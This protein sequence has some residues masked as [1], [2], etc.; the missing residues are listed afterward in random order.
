MGLPRPPTADDDFDGG[1]APFDG[2]HEPFH[3][4]LRLFL[5]Q[6]SWG[7]V[8][9]SRGA[10]TKKEFDGIVD[11]YVTCGYEILDRSG[12][13]TLLR[14]RTWGSP[15]VH[16][17]LAFATFWTLGIGNL[18][19]AL[20]SHINAE[21]VVV[22][23]VPE[24]GG[25]QET[26]DPAPPP[27]TP[28]DGGIVDAAKGMVLMAKQYQPAGASI[29]DNVIVIAL[30]MMCC[31][32]VGL[33]LVWTNPRWT[34]RQ[35]GAWTL[36][37]VPLFMIG[38]CVQDQKAKEAAALL[39]EGDRLWD[40]GKR[41]EAVAK[42]EKAWSEHKETLTSSRQST[43]GVI[44]PHLPNF[45]ARLMQYELSKGDR[46][47]AERLSRQAAREGI[48]LPLDTE[49][50]HKI[51]PSVVIGDA[52]E[53][54]RGGGQV[55]R[56]EPGPQVPTGSTY[57][58]FDAGEKERGGGQ[59]GR[60]E[61]GPQVPTGSTYPKFDAGEKERGGGQVGRHEPGPQ[62]P[63]GS[64][65]PKFNDGFFTDSWDYK[66]GCQVIFDSTVP[67]T[68]AKKLGDYLER[69]GGFDNDPVTFQ[70]RKPGKTYELSLVIKKGLEQDPETIDSMEQLG[71]EL[72]RDVF[73]DGPV[74]VHLCDDRMRTLRVVVP[75]GEPE[76]P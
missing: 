26:I 13:T 38:S 18:A 28:A 12:S 22:N 67:S 53:K 32:P 25:T 4:Q 35:K 7:G 21:Q 69:G 27:W 29:R 48:S 5:T 62:V 9:R 16:L 49:E 36:L 19:Y 65:Y 39:V 61:P 41:Q 20:L 63:T 66:N 31:F 59:V 75:R 46:R 45:Y 42:Y 43:Q 58:K 34:T 3:Q 56:H 44:R 71:L 24:H 40:D 1:H 33:L 50:V 51:D 57:P 72:S 6:K 2:R 11:E 10:A 73:G 30:S 17:I 47:E 64:T 55:G 15:D 60:H 76:P 52:G 54:E 14:K 8:P 70:I 37:L 68:M 23:L 74:D